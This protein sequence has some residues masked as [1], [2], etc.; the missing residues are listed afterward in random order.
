MAVGLST[1]WNAFRSHT[2]EA[3]VGEIAALGFQ[4][5]ELSFNLT[6]QR[7]EDITRLT[8]QQKIEIVSLHNYCPIPEG[9]SPTEALPDCYS[10]ASINEEERKKAVRYTQ[11]TIDTASALAAK[12]VVLHTG[13][14]EMPDVTRDLIAL[15]LRT[16]RETK[17]FQKIKSA[18]FAERENQA[19]PFFENTLRSLEELEQY[20]RDRGLSLGIEN[21]FYCREIPSFAELGVILDKFRGSC[22]H[23]WHDTGHARVIE[24]LGIVRQ[25]EYLQAYGRD[26]CGIHIHNVVDCRDHRAPQS[27][28]IDFS[29]LPSYLKHDTLKII[30]AHHPASAAEVKKGRRFLEVLFDGKP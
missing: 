3:L 11:R 20:A 22:I 26:I 25:N 14:V 28:E 27:G 10:L 1:S 18:F 13:R 6:A 8:R 21:R 4:E 29:D 17:D 24:D 19:A 9:L 2:A 23:Y 15:Y 30:E 12:A 5:I 7:V 16:G